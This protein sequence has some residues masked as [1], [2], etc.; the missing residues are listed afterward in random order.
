MKKY[1][2]LLLGLISLFIVSCTAVPLEKQC[3]VDTDCV[4]A[5]CCHAIDSVNK[6]NAPDCSGVICTMD[7]VPE[8]LD[9]GQGE[10][11]CVKNECVVVLN[12]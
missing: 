4:R 10:I 9:C 1:T 2:L 8:T 7:C 3:A 6:E 11:Q 5:T 12:E